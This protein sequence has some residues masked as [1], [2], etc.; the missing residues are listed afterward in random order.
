VSGVGL[1]LVIRSG[2][3]GD[4]GRIDPGAAAAIAQA[5]QTTDHKRVVVEGIWAIEQFVQRLIIGRKFDLKELTDHGIFQTVTC[6]PRP[7]EIQDGLLTINQWHGHRLPAAA[8]RYKHPRF[9][10]KVLREVGRPPM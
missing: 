6:P 5:T 9:C 7:L 2:I 8:S 10:V 3:Y 1:P 4:R